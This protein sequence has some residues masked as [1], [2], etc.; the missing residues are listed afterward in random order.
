MVFVG[1]FEVDA[2]GMHRITYYRLRY[3]FRCEGLQ[4]LSTSVD[5]SEALYDLL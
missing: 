1:V 5:M 4:A 3:C 2:Q